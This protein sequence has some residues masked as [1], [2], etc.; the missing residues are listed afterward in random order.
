MRQARPGKSPPQRFTLMRHQAGGAPNVTSSF[1]RPALVVVLVLPYTRLRWVLS[2]FTL[3]PHSLLMSSKHFPSRI[4]SAVRISSFVNP[5]ASLRTTLSSRMG[6]LLSRI[7][8]IARGIL[9]ESITKRCSVGRGEKFTV[10]GA[11]PEGRDTETV[12][13]K[14]CADK[15]FGL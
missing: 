13:E 4:S 3:N 8:A 10:N 14:C 9:Q 11:R 7:N 12:L 15:R 6:A 5:K 2:V 1:T